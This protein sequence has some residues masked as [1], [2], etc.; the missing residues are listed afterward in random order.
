M[1]YQESTADQSVPSSHVSGDEGVELSVDPTDGRSLDGVGE[2]EATLGDV[3]QLTGFAD[4][5][6]AE[7]RRALRAAGIKVPEHPTERAS[8]H[9]PSTYM[10][11]SKRPNVDAN[12]GNGESRQNTATRAPGL[13][14][15]L[16]DA[17]MD[18]GLAAVVDEKIAR[19][20]PG[21]MSKVPSSASTWHGQGNVGAAA[22][23]VLADASSD[24]SK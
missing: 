2:A 14:F 9:T 6:E 19:Y 18:P 16:T 17:P 4:T 12:E 24:L 20:A 13:P 11:P 7:F 21:L 5:V 3:A 8:T 1:A 15:E 23:V 22:A 10:R